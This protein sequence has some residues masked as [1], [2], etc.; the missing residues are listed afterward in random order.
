[1]RSLVKTIIYFRLQRLGVLRATGQSGETACAIEKI[2]GDEFGAGI[3]HG[4]LELHE[5]GTYVRLLKI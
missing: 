3:E 5:S 4:W 1:M 2:N